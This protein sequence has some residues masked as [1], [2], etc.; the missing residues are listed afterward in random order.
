MTM[1]VGKLDHYDV[2]TGTLK[3]AVQVYETVL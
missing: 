2:S 3:E 1:S